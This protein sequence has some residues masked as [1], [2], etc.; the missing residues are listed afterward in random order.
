MKVK[1][2]GDLD[3]INNKRGTNE[4]VLKFITQEISDE[5]AGLVMGLRNK[6]LCLMLSTSDATE[7]DVAELEEDFKVVNRLDKKT[8]SQR[9]RAV[10]WHQWDKRQKQRYPDF[11][12]YYARKMETIIDKESELIDG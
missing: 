12:S 9:L 3:S 10:L 7:E 5:D 6:Y 1:V 8:P 2:F 11:E 4:L